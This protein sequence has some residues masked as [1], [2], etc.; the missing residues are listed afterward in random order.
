MKAGTR[1]DHRPFNQADISADDLVWS[2]AVGQELCATLVNVV[3]V[4]QRLK[5]SEV[6]ASSSC[7]APLSAL[8]LNH[9]IS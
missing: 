4:A 6:V 8:G 7:D 3:D 5:R 1:R 9:E 2:D